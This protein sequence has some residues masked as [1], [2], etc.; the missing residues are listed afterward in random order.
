MKVGVCILIVMFA[1]HFAILA[2]ADVDDLEKK[3]LVTGLNV[4]YGLVLDDM[5]NLYFTEFKGGTIKMLPKGESQPVVV[6]SNLTDPYDVTLDRNGN[7]IFSEKI[8]GK[9]SMLT[10]DG[11]VKLILSNVG[12]MY[13]IAVDQDNNIY[14]TV[15]GNPLQS[16]TGTL[17]KADLTGE[18]TELLSGLNFPVGVAVDSQ[19][20]V[21]FTEYGVEGIGTLNVLFA[22]GNL[23]TL[24]TDLSNPAGVA[25]DDAGNVYVCEVPEGTIKMV[26]A[27]FSKV[28]TVATNLTAPWDLAYYNGKLYTVAKSVNGT[29]TQ[30]DLPDVIKPS[31]S[32]TFPLEGQTFT[33]ST[34]TV[35]GTAWDNVAVSKVEV[36]VNNEGWELASGTSY[37]NKQITLNSGSNTIYARATD[38]SGNIGEASVTVTY[39]VDG[40]KPTVPFPLTLSGIIMGVAVIVLAI[41]FSARKKTA[42]KKKYA[43]SIRKR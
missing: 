2:V 5:G 11:N 26:T 27:D 16:G 41:Y 39:S 24:I 17:V 42:V 35:N 7:L 36:K 15:F 14:L 22:D 6:L 40:S 13:G 12:R 1:S 8:G 20:N 10:E 38:T 25:V 23:R 34:I 29:I 19:G 4:P 21:F 28:E 43:K 31:V 3:E 30:I 33:T 18:T 32:I 9:L 37:W